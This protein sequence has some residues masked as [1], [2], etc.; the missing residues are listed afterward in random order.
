M[1]VRWFIDLAAYRI[2]FHL[3]SRI[4]FQQS[5]Q[6]VLLIEV[7]VK[8]YLV[9]FRMEDDWHP[10][11]DLFYK[12]VRIGGD[13]GGRA[14]LPAVF[15]DLP[16]LLRLLREPLLKEGGVRPSRYRMEEPLLP[17]KRQTSRTSR[18]ECD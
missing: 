16:L 9:V 17:L 1:I 10:V 4:G 15:P 13:D 18:F 14:N 3:T 12:L 6:R 2:G 5:C 11:V 8:P 7:G